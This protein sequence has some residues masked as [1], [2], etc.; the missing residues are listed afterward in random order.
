MDL[1]S[2]IPAPIKAAAGSWLIEQTWTHL[3]MAHW[4]V[5]A[6]ELRAVVPHQLAI[7]E[8]DGTG[9]V[10]VVP[11]MTEHVR[12]H[13]LPEVPGVREFPEL[14]VR[15]YVTVDGVP[16]IYFIRIHATNHVVNVTARALAG[17]HYRHAEMGVYDDA[18]VIHYRSVELRDGRRIEW[19]GH[20]RPGGQPRTPATGSL[21][22]WLADRYVAFSVHGGRVLATRIEHAPWTLLDGTLV[23]EH[24]SLFADIGLTVD[25]DQPDLVHHTL[26]QRDVHIWPPRFAG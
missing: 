1:S 18:G 26:G 8:R 20:A 14:N 6:A 11:F 4:R 5:S 3:L 12:L 21:E 16:G 7:E 2:L 23:M 17:V 24:E 15:T 19:A 9:W 22:S 10:S 25:G 13:G